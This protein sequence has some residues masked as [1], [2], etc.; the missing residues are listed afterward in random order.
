MWQ[1]CF[2]YMLNSV[3]SV[4][5]STCIGT[6]EYIQM[7]WSGQ[8]FLYFS[9]LVWPSKGDLFSHFQSLGYRPKLVL[10][11]EKKSLFLGLSDK[12]RKERI[13]EGIQPQT[14]SIREFSRLNLMCV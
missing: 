3:L 12:G 5:E 13:R 1:H 10:P 9:M 7:L 8:I 4:D 6:A 11:T 14:Q 2:A